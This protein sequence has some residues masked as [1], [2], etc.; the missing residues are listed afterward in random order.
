MLMNTLPAVL[1]I[2]SHDKNRDGK[3]TQ[4]EAQNNKHI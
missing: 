4:T 2:Y 1:W 3:P